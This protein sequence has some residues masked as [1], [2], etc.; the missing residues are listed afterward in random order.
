MSSNNQVPTFNMKV[1]VQETGLKPD[2]LRAWER[3]YGVPNPQRT[4]GGH[5]LYSQH[6]ID[7][8]K[9]LVARQDEGMSISH[10]VD[11]WQQ[12]EKEGQDPLQ[13]EETAVAEPTF[14][15]TNGARVDDLRR[16]WIEAS[17][18]YD[19]HNAKFALARA[20]ALLPLETVCF[21]I[22]QQ[23]LNEIGQAWYEGRVSVQQEHFASGLALRQLEAL[24]AAL[25]SPIRSERL[26][27]ACPATEQ[28]TFSPLLIS[29]L[30]RR[31]G[32]DVVYLGANV[33]LDRMEQS[34]RQI[35]PVL[36]I[37]SAQTL[38]A[39][40]NLLPMAQTLQSLG[41]PFAFGGAVFNQLPQLV[42]AIPGH[43]LGQSLANISQ[44]VETLVQT[45]PAI[46]E[47]AQPSKEYQA[48][49]VHFVERRSA[50]EAHIH[51]NASH[52]ELPSSLLTNTNFEFGNDIEAALHLGSLELI[53]INLDWVK[54][55][56]NNFNI[57]TPQTILTNYLRQY[58]QAV[59]VV[60]DERAAPILNWL[61]QLT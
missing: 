23:G 57:Y 11:L 41:V 59:K 42:D 46:T 16:D 35:D 52:A 3:R 13:T 38:T 22:L 51:A 37:M 29:V 47:A 21:K 31:K 12:L 26:I 49:Y 20:F 54:G 15:F 10:A 61:A 18:A 33:P 14:V 25:P 60:M 5:R 17:M 27:V 30:L 44:A 48:A 36:V 58:H 1:V 53:N 8:L 45:K 9:W 39:A 19:E 34:V 28:H 7:L 6:E 2:T 40:G 4:P 56:L 50:I 32:W 43:F 55:L 24:L